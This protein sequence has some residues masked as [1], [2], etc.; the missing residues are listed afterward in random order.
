[1][2]KS[3][4]RVFLIVFIFLQVGLF[5]STYTW[6]AYANK[7]TAYLHE[8]IHIKYVCNFSDASELYTI[9]FNPS[10]EYKK[11]TLK[12]LRESE[13]IVDGKRV[14][15]YE[16]VAFA[17][18]A[19]KIEF[20]FEAIMK[21]TT[22]ESIEDTV[23]GR[24]NVKKEDFTKEPF[25]QKVLR[26]SV[27]ETNS[28][29]VGDFIL[30]TKKNEPKVKAYE[31]Y[32]MQVAIK[33]VGNFEALKPIAFSIEGVR[34]FAE[35]V[36]QDYKLSEDGLHGEWIQKFA[37]VSEKHF[38]VP[39]VEIEYFSLREQK[40]QKLVINALD[41]SVEAG[42]SKEELLD[43]EPKKSFEFDYSYFYYLLAFVAGFLVAK[44]KIKRRVTKKNSDEEFRQKVQEAKSLDELM[45]LLV[46]KDAKRYEKIIYDIE[47]KK[48]ASLKNAK[49][50]IVD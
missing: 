18:E 24:D 6:S 7:T 16:F 46:L 4:G 49:R 10:G 33:G 12:N 36:A 15:S 25:K 31:P 8:A 38:T 28:S 40:L 32:H 19:G 44:I 14:N 9:E 3:L 34:V 22:K 37:F 17:K 42:F 29:L 11:F 23:I 13:Q 50:L 30:E 20:A 47:T 2:K 41:V 35:E 48:V 21:K 1:M 27:K 43:E 26:V 39:R 45:I 5:A